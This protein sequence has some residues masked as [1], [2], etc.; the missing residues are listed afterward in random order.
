MS[1]HDEESPSAGQRRRGHEE[2]LALCNEAVQSGEY[3]L[4]TEKAWDRLCQEAVARGRTA[5]Q[6]PGA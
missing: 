6:T 2:E 1:D 5:S 3:D 4:R